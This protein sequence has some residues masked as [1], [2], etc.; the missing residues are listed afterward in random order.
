MP[1]EVPYMDLRRGTDRQ[2]GRDEGAGAERV[3]AVS[4]G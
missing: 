4:A 1:G 3:P 2:C